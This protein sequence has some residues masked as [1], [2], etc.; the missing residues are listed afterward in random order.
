M[1]DAAVKNPETLKWVPLN[2]RWAM[3]NPGKSGDQDDGNEEDHDN[4][5]GGEP[6]S[7]NL[8]AAYPPLPTKQNPLA[9]AMYGQI[10]IAAKSYQ[11]AICECI[12]TLHRRFY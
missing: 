4:P 12:H 9:V 11:S 7:D 3:I 10:C 2:K 1:A 6:E 5:E 8:S